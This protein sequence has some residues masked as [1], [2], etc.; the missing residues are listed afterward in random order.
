MLKL[1]NINLTLGKET[2]L[3]RQII[4]D[5]DLTVTAGEFVVFIG[6]N[7]AGKSTLFSLISGYLFPDQ[8]TIT[9]DHQDIT[10]WPQFKRA[11]YVAEVMQDPKMG[12]MEN[13]TIAENMSFAYCRGKRR[14]LIP[15][16]SCMRKK[17]FQEKLSMLNMGLEDRMDELVGNLSG[18]QRQA[19]ALIMAILCDSKILL[20][21]EITAALDPKTAENV[22]QLAAK[23][24]RDEKR[25][26]LMITHNMDHAI[27]YGD[28]TLLL[29]N[30]KVFKEY[31]SVAKKSLTPLILAKDFYE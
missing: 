8:G 2:L 1:N 5:L 13:L 31:D 14:K 18:G 12:T 4:K 26:T 19:L 29:A 15:Y 3:E 17:L 11:Q 7:G 6:G 20:L 16:T 24:V 23:I 21:D 27:K 25:T 30:G 22:M 9:L 10:K 28:R